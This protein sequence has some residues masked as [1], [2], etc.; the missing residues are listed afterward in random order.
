MI[1]MLIVVAIISIL[2]GITLETFFTANKTQALEKDTASIKAILERARSLTL[3]AY[4][5]QPYGVHLQSDRVVLFRGSSYDASTSTN[6]VE[7]LNA[8]VAISAHTLA[9]GGDDVL[10]QRLTGKTDNSGTITV[11]LLSDSSKF[12]TI[13]INSTGLVE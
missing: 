6:N 8:A 10:F 9:G 2:A 11:S 5:D 7:M 13:T 1:E 4:V 12:F 3:S